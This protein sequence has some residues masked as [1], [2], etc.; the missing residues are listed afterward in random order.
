MI[1]VVEYRRSP[2]RYLLARGASSRAAGPIGSAL[3]GSLAPLRLINRPDPKRIAASWVRVRPL[4]AGICGADLGL[5]TGRSSPYLST[6]VSTPFVPGHEVVGELLDPAGELAAGSRVVIDPVLRCA[7]RDVEDCAACVTGHR[8]R[9][10]HITA[11]TVSAGLQT[12]FCSDTGGGWSGMLVA[13]TSQLHPVP[14]GMRN[15]RAV[16]VEPLAC[17]VHAVHRAAIPD[18]ASVV[19][20]GAGTIGLLALL[21]LREFARPGPVYVIAKHPHQADRARA[22]GAT[23]VLDPTQAAR[24]LRRATGGSLHSPAG[25]GDFLLGGVDIAI[26]TTGESGLSAALRLTRGGGTVVLCGMPPADVDLTPAWFR[27]L[28]VIGAY[29]SCHP[30]GRRDRPGPDRRGDFGDAM[31][32]AGRAP[33][34]GFVDATYPLSQWREAIGHAVAAGRLGSVKVAF[35]PTRN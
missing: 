19:V 34:D 1:T 16:L 20:V 21:A 25:G 4:L 28:T 12:G 15:E 14:D 9:C 5:V 22:L 18:G 17:A 27:E 26:E 35:D 8:N 23:D 33:L 6:M 31:A 30:A 29:A 3:A 10:E 7:T 2:S 13:H 24:A 32:L 11:G